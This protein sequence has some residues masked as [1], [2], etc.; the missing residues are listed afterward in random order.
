MLESSMPVEEPPV[1]IVN[2]AVALQFAES[3]MK[4]GEIVHRAPGGSAPQD[5]VTV[6]LKPP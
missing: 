4:D 1:A 5:N 3:V 6:W 2:V